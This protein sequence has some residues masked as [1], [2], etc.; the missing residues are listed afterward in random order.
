MSIA[1]RDGRP[2]DGAAVSGVF[3]RA[4]T[5]TFGHLYSAANLQYLLDRRAPENFE[6]QL[7]SSDW[8]FRLAEDDG[9]L[10][11]YAMGGPN[12]LPGDVPGPTWELHH[13]Y[14]D[15]AAKGRGIADTLFDWTCDEARR[16]DF[17]HLQLSVFI[18]NHRARRFYDKRGMIEVGKYVFMVGDHED[19]DRVMRLAL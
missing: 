2:G 13:L 7:G 1:Y 6:E 3:H 16:R 4:F 5:A 18:D 14:L 11:G 19:D 8:A 15:E 10:L 9:V 12:E 17:A